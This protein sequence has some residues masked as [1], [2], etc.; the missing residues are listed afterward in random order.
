M[1]DQPGFGSAAH[2]RI[3]NKSKLLSGMVDRCSKRELEM[4]I[5]YY[6]H[7]Q[8][9][10]QV[11]REMECSAEEFE[12][13]RVKMRSSVIPQDPLKSRAAST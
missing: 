8:D 3:A 7:G 10:Q 6:I 13:L 12:R 4:L 11:I 1:T 5:R 2:H 9:E